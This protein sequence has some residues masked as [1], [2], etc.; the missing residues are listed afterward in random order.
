MT[1]TALQDIRVLDFGHVLAG[2]VAAM[3]LADLGA[4]VLHIE[5]FAGDDARQFGP[6]LNNQSAYFMSVNRNKKSI[7]IDMKKEQGKSIIRK[8]IARSDVI[9]E[10]FRPDVMEKLGFSY[11][12]AKKINPGIIYASISGFGHDS[13]PEYKS[14]PSYDMIAQAYSGFMS[15]TGTE[16]G[17]KVRAGSSIG[18]I[19]AGHQC[20]ISILAALHHRQKTG[21][22]QL[23]DQAMVDGLIYTLENAIVRYSVSDETPVPLGTKHPSVT[24]FQAF[25]TKDGDIVIPV[26]NNSL[27]KKFCTVLGRD[28][29]AEDERFATNE[30][31]T[32]N[33]DVLIDLIQTVLME[34]TCA[35]WQELLREHGIP[36]S[37]V[38]SIPQVVADENLKHRKMIVSVEQPTAGT[39]TVAGSPFKMSRTPGDVR[40]PAPLLGEHTREVL[41][42]VLGY[43]DT[44]IESLIEEQVVL[45]ADH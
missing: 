5:P 13:L 12:E 32:D 34:K 16:S 29:W 39:L 28:E 44:E 31:R 19:V 3:I 45:E 40:A 43:S 22:G 30:L 10:N 27:W 2:P 26:G 15:I 24:P 33:R 42:E 1:P 21:E 25:K 36:N 14:R 18:D 7:A 41:D 4:D 35:E 37:P 20:A 23:I 6:F 11:E 17:E 8:L 38:N 9:I